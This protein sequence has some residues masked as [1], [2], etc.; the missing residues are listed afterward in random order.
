MELWVPQLLG[1]AEALPEHHG[2][3]PNSGPFAREVRPA[4]QHHWCCSPERAG[5]TMPTGDT[6][7]L[8]HEH[9]P[10]G[11]HTC[12]CPSVCR[13]AQARTCHTHAC[14]HQRVR[15]HAH[16]CSRATCTQVGGPNVHAHAHTHAHARAYTFPSLHLHLQC[17]CT[18]SCSCAFA[19]ACAHAH[20][21]A[22]AHAHA[23]A[24]AHAH[25]HTHVFGLALTDASVQVCALARV[26]SHT[27]SHVHL[28]R[29]RACTWMC[30]PKHTL[31][32]CSLLCAYRGSCAHAWTHAKMPR[33]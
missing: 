12:A 19:R 1:G 2:C 21:R 23:H 13:R 11:M 20:A 25:T 30:A 3:P 5:P 14:G 29:A 28:L 33:H 18:C 9:T 15:M 7:T 24:D 26:Y 4:L 27:H 8:V 32:T 22:H 6:S 10:T 17:T 31:H 16:T